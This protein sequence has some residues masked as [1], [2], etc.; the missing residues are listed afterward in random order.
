MTDSFTGEVKTKICFTS[1]PGYIIENE[2]NHSVINVSCRY[3]FTYSY[4]FNIQGN[5]KFVNLR[6]YFKN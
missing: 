3:F 1:M 4:S 6:N 2:G 5:D